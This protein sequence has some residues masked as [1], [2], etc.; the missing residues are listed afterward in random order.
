MALLYLV[1]IEIKTPAQ[2]F[3][4]LGLGSLGGASVQQ[5][6]SR[7]EAVT[8]AAVRGPQPPLEPLGEP[9][10]IAKPQPALSDTSNPSVVYFAPPLEFGRPDKNIIVTG[11]VDL[12]VGDTGRSGQPFYIE[13][14]AADRRVISKVLPEYPPGYQKEAIVAL[15]FEVLP[16]GL[17]TGAIIERK[18]D[19]VLEQVAVEAF[20]QWVF[21]PVP[22]KTGIMAGRVTFVFKV[23]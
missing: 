23:K 18:G 13:G 5:I 12:G 14:R 7:V 11:D 16:S 9:I 22:E 3:V 4:S 1:Y 8:A 21:E 15:A 20:R 17:V 2:E 10:P 6:L 19:P